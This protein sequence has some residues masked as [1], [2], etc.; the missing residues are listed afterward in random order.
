MQLTNIL[1]FATL[2]ILPAVAAPNAD[3][4]EARTGGQCKPNLYWNGFHKA[5]QCENKACSYD[6]SQKKCHYP[7]HSKP[8]CKKEEIVYCARSSTD[9][10]K[11]NGNDDRCYDDGKSQVFCCKEK[12]IPKKVKEVCPPSHPSCPNSQHWDYQSRGCVCEKG[13]MW[14]NNKCCHKPIVKPTCPYGQRPYCA[15]D[16]KSYVIYDDKNDYCD[17]NGH[18]IA[19]CCAPPKIQETCSKKWN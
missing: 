11:W 19:F 7:L 8:S 17:D 6:N 1:A 12:D 3:A 4:L 13:K 16:A 2:A 5:C 9:Y 15:K 10:C 14:R 18:N